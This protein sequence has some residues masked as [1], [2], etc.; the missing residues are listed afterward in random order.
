MNVGK[1]AIASAVTAA[2]LAAMQFAWADGVLEEFPRAANDVPDLS[3]VWQT[4][5]T[6]HWNLEPHASA[7][8][9]IPDLGAQFAV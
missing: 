7:Y 3:G 4:L 8:P 6:A 2:A 1:P 9:V 5:N